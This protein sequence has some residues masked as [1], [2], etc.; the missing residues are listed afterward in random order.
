HFEPRS[1]HPVLDNP[2]FQRQTARDRYWG[3]KRILAFTPEELRA[4]IAEG[5]YRPEAAE[6]LYEILIARREK[7]ARTFLADLPALDHFRLDADRLCFDDLW[8]DAGLGGDHAT[9]YSMTGDGVTASPHRC[10]QLAPFDGY[11]IVALRV[12]RPGE[13]KFSRAVNV[14]LMEESGRRRIIG[15]ER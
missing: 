10:A 2:A 11:R 9:A 13:R 1:W 15:I 4:A 12:R 7:M 8:L 6:R 5:R 3:M 14:H